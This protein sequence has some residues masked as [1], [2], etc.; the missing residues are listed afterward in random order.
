MVLNFLF[1][2]EF[3]LLSLIYVTGFLANVLYIRHCIGKG[4]TRSYHASCL[5]PEENLFLPIWYCCECTKK[6][7]TLGVHSLSEGI[8]SIWD[9]REVELSNSTGIV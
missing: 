5:T 6:R 4:C 7:L 2:A 1:G 9:V 3:S 8:E